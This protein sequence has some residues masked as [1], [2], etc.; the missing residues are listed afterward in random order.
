MIEEVLDWLAIGDVADDTGE[1]AKPCPEVF[2]FLVRVE[3]TILELVLS[4]VAFDSARS[5]PRP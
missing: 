1:E 4:L 5:S 3:G 2:R